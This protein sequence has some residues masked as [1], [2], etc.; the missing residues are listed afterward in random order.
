[1][2][3]RL[4]IF[5][6]EKIENIILYI[7][8]VIVVLYLFYYLYRQYQPSSDVENFKN[9]K[10]QEKNIEFT[11]QILGNPPYK[12]YEDYKCVTGLTNYLSYFLTTQSKKDD[13]KIQNM[14]PT[15]MSVKVCNKSGGDLIN[16][17]PTNN[18]MWSYL[19]LRNENIDGTTKKKIPLVVELSF[20][21]IIGFYVDIPTDVMGSFTINLPTNEIVKVMRRDNP[22]ILYRDEMKMRLIVGDD[23]I[24]I[25]MILKENGKQKFGYNVSVGDIYGKSNKNSKLDTYRIRKSKITHIENCIYLGNDKNVDTTLRD[26]YYC[27]PQKFRLCSGKKSYKVLNPDFTKYPLKKCMITKDKKISC[28]LESLPQG[29]QGCTYPKEDNLSGLYSDDISGVDILK[30]NPRVVCSPDAFRMC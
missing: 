1:M 25:P 15:Q 30:N 11:L 8:I 27:L 21:K 3:S 16:M 19:I 10:V 24:A 20:K 9:K 17:K 4:S 23:T 7:F 26:Q 28:P 29:L 2:K 13:K 12:G 14:T 6:K 18:N 5:G 22:N